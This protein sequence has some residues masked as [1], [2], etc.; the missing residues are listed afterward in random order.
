MRFLQIHQ[1]IP[2]PF[3]NSQHGKPNP[4]L[5]IYC[6]KVR[7]MEQ[8]F[9]RTKPNVT[10]FYSIILGQWATDVIKCNMAGMFW[11]VA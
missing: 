10:L 9:E 5:Q 11:T 1:H 7:E 6:S 8:Q 4:S 3:F 2:K